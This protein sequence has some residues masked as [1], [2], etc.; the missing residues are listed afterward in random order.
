MLN[1]RMKE[2]ALLEA[3]ADAALLCLAFTLAFLVRSYGVVPFLEDQTT[4]RPDLASHVWLLF[5][6]V[7]LFW[8]LGAQSKIYLEPRPTS[9]LGLL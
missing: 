9:Y 4:T 6:S 5:L 3:T 8:V 7:P 2:R 1:Q